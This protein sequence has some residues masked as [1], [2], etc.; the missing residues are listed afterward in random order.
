M[1]HCIRMK[2]TDMNIELQS[3]NFNKDGLKSMSKN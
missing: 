1:A 3:P 2:N